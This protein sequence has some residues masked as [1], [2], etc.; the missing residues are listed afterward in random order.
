MGGLGLCLTPPVA[1]LHVHLDETGN[2][3]FA[4]TGGRADYTIAALRW[5]TAPEGLQPCGVPVL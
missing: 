3:K 5:S 2:F 1:T 4:P